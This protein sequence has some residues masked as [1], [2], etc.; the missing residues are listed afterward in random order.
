MKPIAAILA[1]L[2][3]C[4]VPAAVAGALDETPIAWGETDE[5]ETTVCAKRWHAL[6][7]R[8]IRTRAIEEG[9]GA[10]EQ[11][12]LETQAV[13]KGTVDCLT[14]KVTYRPV[15][16]AD[17]ILGAETWVQLV[18]PDGPVPCRGGLRCRWAVQSQNFVEAEVEIDGRKNPETVYVA[19][20]R[21]VQPGRIGGPPPMDGTMGASGSASPPAGASR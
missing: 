11:V 2:F 18:S 4:P 10:E 6:K 3:L 17:V 7:L 14:A 21:P 20:P 5:R 12:R 1:L 9:A 8:D 13:L 15:L 19:T 16:H